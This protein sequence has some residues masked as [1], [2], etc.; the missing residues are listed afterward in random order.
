MRK[1]LLPETGT[2][3][4]ANLHCHTTVSDGDMTPQDFMKKAW[5]AA[6]RLRAM[7]YGE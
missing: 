7:A 2:F 1:Y 5:D 4:K 6:V 3:F